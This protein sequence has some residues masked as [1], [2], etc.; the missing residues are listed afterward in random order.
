MSKMNKVFYKPD[1]PTCHSEIQMTRSTKVYYVTGEKFS[2]KSLVFIQF[3]QNLE[4]KNMKINK[5][6]F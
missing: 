2:L 6:L 5:N 3:F 1:P 4:K